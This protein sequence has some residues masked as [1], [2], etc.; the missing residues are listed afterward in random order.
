MRVDAFLCDA[1]TVREGLL[2]VLGAGIT[3]VQRPRYPAPLNLAVAMIVSLSPAETHTGH[4]IRVAVSG[5]DGQPI[6]S[7]DGEFT[8]KPGPDHYPGEDSHSSVVINLQ[9]ALPSP[10]VYAVDIM[11]DGSEKAHLQFSASQ[12]DPNHPFER[13]PGDDSPDE[14]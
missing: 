7:I 11:I 10:G 12:H 2:H 4:K 5:T 1:A 14:G 8:A 13:P 3:R 9:D 6:L